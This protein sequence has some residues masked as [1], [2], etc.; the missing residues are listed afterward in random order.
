MEHHSNIVPWQ[1]ACARTGAHLKVI[2]VSDTG[3]ILLDAYKKLLSPRTKLVSVA[4]ISNVLG[5]INPIAEMAALAHVHGAKMLVD[6]AQSIAH[7]SV[8]VQKLG[9][10]FLFSPGTRPTALQ[11]SACST[12]K[13]G[14]PKSPSLSRRGRYGGNRDL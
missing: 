8:D 4:H 3:E 11:A 7:L 5:T 13:K 10:D 14:T 9:V 6:G 2:P 12:G 1:M